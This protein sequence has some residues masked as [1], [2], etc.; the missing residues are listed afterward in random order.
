MAKP[1]GKAPFPTAIDH[2]TAGRSALDPSRLAIRW[3]PGTTEAQRE[4]LLEELGL[5][6]A[7]LENAQRPALAINRTEGLWWTRTPGDVLSAETVERLEASD[8]V[9]WISPAYRSGDA[10]DD[11]TRYAVN[12]TRLFIR[13]ES[14]DAMGGVTA[15]GP[16]L[17]IDTTQVTA[18][19]SLVALRVEQPSASQGRTALHIAARLPQSQRTAVRFENIPYLSP[20]ASVDRRCAPPIS[21]FVPD[22]PLYAN[23]WGLQRVGA[24]RGWEIARGNADITIAV[25][26]EGVELGHPDL[27]VHPQ[28]WTPRTGAWF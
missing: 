1:S 21:Q 27:Q 23:Q 2:P 25:I 14:L 28:S 20:T 22:D 7:A 6:P 16:D 10:S 26:D 18:I 11:G 3:R 24:P 8:V 12:P 9:E 19:P 13:Q 15:L 17:A 5:V 4:A